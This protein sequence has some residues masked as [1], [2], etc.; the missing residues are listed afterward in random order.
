MENA[1]YEALITDIRN[2][3][4]LEARSFAEEN[5]DVNS[6]EIEY[7][8][9]FATPIYITFDGENIN[10]T[11]DVTYE[12]GERVSKQLYKDVKEMAFDFVNEYRDELADQESLEEYNDN[13]KSLNSQ[14]ENDKL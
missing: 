7:T 11:F 3:I 4:I 13:M 8:K 2:Y 5:K 10:N 6:V 14:Y 12:D 1:N 9:F